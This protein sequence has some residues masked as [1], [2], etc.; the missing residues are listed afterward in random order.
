MDTM[1]SL[2]ASRA[3]SAYGSRPTSP[4]VNRDT[5]RRDPLYGQMQLQPQQQYPQQQ[6]QEQQQQQPQPQYEQY[7]YNSSSKSMDV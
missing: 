3:A 4:Y 1:S 6:Q 5:W 7:V 2:P